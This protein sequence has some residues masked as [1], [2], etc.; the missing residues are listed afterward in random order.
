M[1]NQL[2][3]IDRPHPQRRQLQVQGKRALVLARF[4][5]R[6]AGLVRARL[7]AADPSFPLWRNMLCRTT[8]GGYA[9]TC[10]AIRDTDLMES[11]AR[12]RLPCLGICGDQDGATPPDLVRETTDLIPGSR[13][14]LIKG[15]GHIPCVEQPAALAAAIN[16][17][18]KEIG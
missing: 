18:L 1:P 2:S 3:K 12:L 4:H 8:P 7:R 5:G 16:G 6:R 14:E 10:R 15:A 11:T 17:F 9:G 13:F